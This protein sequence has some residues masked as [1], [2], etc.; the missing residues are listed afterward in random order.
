MGQILVCG[1]IQLRSQLQL[2][3]EKIKVMGLFV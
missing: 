1:L 2:C 3:T